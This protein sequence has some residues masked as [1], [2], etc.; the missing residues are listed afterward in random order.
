MVTK[1]AWYWYRRRHVDQWNRIDDTE[2]KS[3]TYRHLVFDKEV[4]TIQWENKASS[5]N[6]PGLT[7]V[8][9]EKNEDR[10]IIIPL[11][12]I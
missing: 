7:D 4:K 10:Y 5:S 9:M 8:Y 1:T 3:Q 6:D 12:K 11:H 2:I